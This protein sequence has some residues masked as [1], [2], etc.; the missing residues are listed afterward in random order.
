[1]NMYLDRS[2]LQVQK[3]QCGKAST[4]T[5]YNSHFFLDSFIGY[6]AA[7]AEAKAD[8]I[9]SLGEIALWAPSEK[10]SHKYFPLF[11]MMMHIIFTLIME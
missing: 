11:R 8:L 4:I 3:F 6:W 1:M 7:C 10:F 5:Y 9:T 2:K